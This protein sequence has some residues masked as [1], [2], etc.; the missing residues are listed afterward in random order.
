MLKKREKERKLRNNVLLLRLLLPLIIT[1]WWWSYVSHPHEKW[2]KRKTGWK[3]SIS[4]WVFSFIFQVFWLLPSTQAYNL[5]LLIFF[6][7]PHRL[8]ICRVLICMCVCCV[9]VTQR[10]LPSWLKCCL[11]EKIITYQ[12]LRLC[13]LMHA[14]SSASRRISH[15][16]YK[17]GPASWSKEDERIWK[18]GKINHPNIFYRTK[19]RWKSSEQGDCYISVTL[20]DKSIMFWEALC[21]WM[22]MKSVQMITHPDYKD[23]ESECCTLGM[24][25][26][27]APSFWYLIA[28]PFIWCHPHVWR[29]SR[30][31]RQVN[32]Y[33]YDA[34]V[35]IPALARHGWRQRR[36]MVA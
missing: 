29:C 2:S 9:C 14:S 6:H 19:R 5:R 33:K 30:S 34:A 7:L 13:C 16:S 3:E 32:E 17:S 8:S 4:V 25:I 24:K 12:S 36:E 23:T 1:T 31:D 15:A 18:T 20:Y 35:C 22:S 26:V 28:S 10:R 21:S 11:G 27:K